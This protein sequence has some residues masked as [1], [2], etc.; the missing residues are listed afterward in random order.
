VD[1][2][3]IELLIVGGPVIESEARARLPV[4]VRASCCK[5]LR[6]GEW[7][8]SGKHGEERD[9]VLSVLVNRLR[10]LMVA[11]RMHW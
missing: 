7:V 9:D 4:Q 3:T 6:Y 1:N 8:G 11:W 5:G 10:R 2:K